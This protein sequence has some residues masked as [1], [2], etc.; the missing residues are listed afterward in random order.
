MMYVSN[1]LYSTNIYH[2]ILLYENISGNLLT[3]YCCLWRLTN[4]MPTMHGQQHPVSTLISCSWNTWKIK[5]WKIAHPWWDSKPRSLD[6]K[7]SALR[8]LKVTME[9]GGCLNTNMSSHQYRDP[10]VQIRGSHDRLISLTW[11]SP[12]LAKTVFTLRW[13]T[14][15]WS[16]YK[17]ILWLMIAKI[18]IIILQQ[19]VLLYKI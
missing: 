12:C 13:K 15:T 18:I 9:P 3:V 14:R 16:C 4:D 6:Y 2:K 11:E 5:K 10:H 17:S 8:L 1:A 7:E 19:D